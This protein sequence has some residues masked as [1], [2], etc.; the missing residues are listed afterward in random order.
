MQ[1]ARDPLRSQPFTPTTIRNAESTHDASQ[2]QNPKSGRAPRRTD[3]SIDEQQFPAHP[4]VRIPP[5]VK[6][7]AMPRGVGVAPRPAKGSTASYSQDKVPRQR[8]TSK[9]STPSNAAWETS[10]SH[11]MSMHTPPPIPPSTSSSRRYNMTQSYVSDVAGDNAY[12]SPLLKQAFP[13]R[14]SHYPEDDFSPRAAYPSSRLMPQAEFGTPDNR[15]TMQTVDSLDQFPKPRP[16]AIDTSLRPSVSMKPGE[17]SPASTRAHAMNALSQAI[18]VGINQPSKPV[19]PMTMSRRTSRPFSPAVRMPFDNDSNSVHT[20]NEDIE[21]PELKDAPPVPNLRSKINPRNLSTSPNSTSS[22]APIL[23][24]GIAEP[25]RG[26]STKR[27]ASK[28]PARLDIDAVRDMEARGS[29]TSLTDLIKRAT[30]LASNLDRGKTASRLGMLDMFGKNSAERLGNLP[31]GKRDS[32]MSD[33]LSAFPAPAIG[34]P[35]SEWPGH[36]EKGGFNT[37]TSALPKYHSDSSLNS[38]AKRQKAARR[39]ICGMSVPC[40]TVIIIILILLI[41]AAVLIPIFLIVV[42]RQSANYNTTAIASLASCP[43]TT[44]CANGGTSIF[45]YNKCGCICAGNFTGPTCATAGDNSCTTRDIQDGST[46]YRSATLGTQVLQ[47]FTDASTFR[48]SLNA[49][50]VLAQFTSNNIPCR[51]ANDLLDVNPSEGN[52]TSTTSAATNNKRETAPEPFIMLK[53]Y[54]P[55]PLPVQPHRIGIV[56]HAELP[57]ITAAPTFATIRRRQEASNTLFSEESIVFDTARGTAITISA[58]PTQFSGA[59]SQP[60]NSASASPSGASS[61]SNPSTSLPS[62]LSFARVV[63]LYILEHSQSLATAL[64]AKNRL[65]KYFESVGS[66]DEVQVGMVAGLM[67]SVDMVALTLRDG[68]TVVNAQ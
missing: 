19:S 34:T 39:R 49:T 51:E 29:T 64:D 28:R 4:S 21:P 59:A 14:E 54:E 27:D 53:G 52:S 9:S 36:N 46:I 40:F 22:Q 44:R 60:T 68:D 45:T 18:A 38:T 42:P 35:R 20:T 31:A 2:Y 62:Q 6:L 17:I 3:Y 23:G 37:S 33:M 12:D 13:P 16:S 66:G 48:I 24:L 58:S 15:A 32:S 57:Q 56:Q 47:G 65:A 67:V 41:A 61:N 11:A 8:A 1:S 63:I 26:L 5:G 43:E 55:L 10:Q 30:R 25:G 7:K 50:T